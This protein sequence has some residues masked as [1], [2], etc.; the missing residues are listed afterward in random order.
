[1]RPGGGASSRCAE[2]RTPRTA[3]AGGGSLSIPSLEPRR[4]A[5]GGAVNPHSASAGPKGPARLL[6]GRGGEHTAAPRGL[7]GRP[8]AGARLTLRR[9]RVS[10]ARP[11]WW[12]PESHAAATPTARAV[13]GEPGPGGRPPGRSGPVGGSGRA[14]GG[15]GTA[16]AGAQRRQGEAGVRRGAAG[17][18]Q[19]SERAPPSPDVSSGCPRSRAS[20]GAGGSG[21]GHR[22]PRQAGG[23][24]WGALGAA[25]AA[26]PASPRRPSARGGDQ[27]N[28]P[29]QQK[30]TCIYY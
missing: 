17:A 8:A 7:T 20:G 30:I 19:A 21:G 15:R 3:K 23:R 26:G 24:A 29:L 27:A 6:Q 2:G 13:R 1:M 5:G 10:R 4:N 16:A 12:H 9:P 28:S 11:G 14:G 18:E 25:P 22:A